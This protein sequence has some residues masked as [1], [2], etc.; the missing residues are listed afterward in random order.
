MNERQEEEI[1]SLPCY[2]CPL[3]ACD[4][5]KEH[6]GAARGVATILMMALSMDEAHSKIKQVTAKAVREAGFECPVGE[7]EKLVGTIHSVLD[8]AYQ[9]A[10]EN[11]QAQ[12]LNTPKV[13]AEAKKIMGV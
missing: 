8:L 1:R 11:Q 12:E 13:V 6:L 10:K 9:H 5:L 2:D 7:N 4:S 3:F